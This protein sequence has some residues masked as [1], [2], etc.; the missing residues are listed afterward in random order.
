MASTMNDKRLPNLQ[1]LLAVLFSIAAVFAPLLMTRGNLVIGTLIALGLLLG[2][3]TLAIGY[4]AAV[5]KRPVQYPF[6]GWSLRVLRIFAGEGA[7]RSM[8]PTPRRGQNPAPRGSLQVI[9][10][11]NLILGG[12]LVLGMGYAIVTLI[13]FP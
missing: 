11:V 6:Y 12:L 5:Q 8:N 7:V 13:N 10:V 4:R 9:G 3:V 1:I 2:A